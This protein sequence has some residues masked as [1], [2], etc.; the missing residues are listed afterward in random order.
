MFLSAY[1]A[2]T[3]SPYELGCGPI[4]DCVLDKIKCGLSSIFKHLHDEDASVGSQSWS[5]QFI[6]GLELFFINS[7]A[8][9]AT[10]ARLSL[11]TPE[12]GSTAHEVHVVDAP[13]KPSNLADRVYELKRLSKDLRMMS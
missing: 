9:S 10:I 7:Q 4:Y 13:I 2:C 12:E 8:F 1:A 11:C 5:S 6:Q 3:V